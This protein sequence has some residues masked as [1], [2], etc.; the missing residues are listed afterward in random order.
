MRSENVPK[1]P[2]RLPNSSA[3]RR[4]AGRGRLYLPRSAAERKRNETVR[5]SLAL[6]SNNARRRSLKP[7]S[8]KRLTRNCK[9]PEPLR[10][11]PRSN[12]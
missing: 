3:K 8:Y 4:N 2:A 7:K 6:S 9:L 10:K 1:K 11:L 12:G 5:R